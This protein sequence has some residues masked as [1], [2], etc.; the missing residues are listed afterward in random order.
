MSGR[1]I[2]PGRMRCP[3]THRARARCG[4]GCWTDLA[5]SLDVRSAGVRLENRSDPRAE[6]HS[7]RGPSCTERVHPPCIAGRQT[8]RSTMHPRLSRATHDLPRTAAH[9]CTIHRLRRSH[10][11]PPERHSEIRPIRRVT[12]PRERVPRRNAAHAPAACASHPGAR[13]RRWCSGS[14]WGCWRGTSSPACRW[15]C[16]FPSSS[17]PRWPRCW[18]SG[19]VRVGPACRPALLLLPLGFFSVMV[20]VRGP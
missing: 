16:P 5:S 7:V 15:E 19:A 2:A 3:G 17:S 8:T 1:V 13:G 18:C 9:R 12:A 6:D 4:P 20:A 11:A 10:P 14:G